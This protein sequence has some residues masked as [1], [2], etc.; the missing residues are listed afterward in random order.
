MIGIYAMKHYQIP[1]EQFI[2]WIRIA[3]PGSVLGP[4]QFFLCQKEAEYLLP[5]HQSPFKRSFSTK[6]EDMS[7]ID[8]IKSIKGE[9]FQGNYLVNAKERHSEKKGYRGHGSNSRVRA[10]YS[11]SSSKADSRTMYA[12]GY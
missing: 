2:G 7:P 3:R 12:F 10:T 5:Q 1:A 4:Q 8:R 6:V 11:N 9:A